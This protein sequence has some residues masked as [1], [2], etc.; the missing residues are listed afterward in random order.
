MY[1]ELYLV[2][3]SGLISDLPCQWDVFSQMR[4]LKSPRLSRWFYRSLLSGSKNEKTWD[5]SAI[6]NLMLSRYSNILSNCSILFLTMF[7]TLRTLAEFLGRLWEQQLTVLRHCWSSCSST[8]TP[9][10]SLS[11]PPLSHKILRKVSNHVFT[12]F[13]ML[14][15]W[16]GG[17]GTPTRVH[18]QMTSCQ[19]HPTLS[20]YCGCWRNDHEPTSPL[21]STR[22]D[23][24][25]QPLRTSFLF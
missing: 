4:V 14:F 20:T 2:A 17:V 18:R 10:P 24:E 16:S 7:Q 11:S 13:T 5:S 12:W 21:A 9:L 3:I 23:D 6:F 19:P 8:L 1:L 15:I 22:P 25:E